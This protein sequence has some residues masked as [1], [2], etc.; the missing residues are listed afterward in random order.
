[1]NKINFQGLNPQEIQSVVG[2]AQAEKVN[3]LKLL[4]QKLGLFEKI[5]NLKPDLPQ[6]QV[7]LI[8]AQ[9]EDIIAGPENR[10]LLED[11][12]QANRKEIEKFK[13]YLKQE[14]ADD[15]LQKLIDEAAE[16]LGSTI[17][18]ISTE[19]LLEAIGEYIKAA[20]P[21]LYDEYNRRLKARKNTLPS[22]INESDREE[23]IK[24]F[25]QDNFRSENE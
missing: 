1:M 16:N 5:Q 2:S 7:D 22:N 12:K 23:Y 9:T 11:V 8:E 14:G 3:N 19:S 13:V 6:A 25:M 4:E 20:D 21:D 18:G 10:R 15:R 17:E 24:N